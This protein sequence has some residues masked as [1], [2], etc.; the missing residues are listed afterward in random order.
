[1]N[2]GLPV[3]Q[4]GGGSFTSSPVINI[5]GDASERTVGLIEMRLRDYEER[6]QQIAQGVSQQTIQEENE[7]GGFLNPI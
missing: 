6:V 2:A 7:V 4:G 5:Q 1:M 3:R